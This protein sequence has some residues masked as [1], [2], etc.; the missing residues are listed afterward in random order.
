MGAYLAR[1]SLFL[2]AVPHTEQRNSRKSE[3]DRLCDLSLSFVL[4]AEAK[5]R[6]EAKGLFTRNTIT[7][8]NNPLPVRSHGESSRTNPM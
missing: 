3:C 8:L 7:T 6:N 4:K 1:Y 5:A 2:T